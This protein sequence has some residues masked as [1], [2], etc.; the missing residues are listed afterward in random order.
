MW[1]IIDSA[2]LDLLL[3]ERLSSRIDW[4]MLKQFVLLGELTRIVPFLPDIPAKP[5]LRL[6]GLITARLKGS[7]TN[8]PS[9]LHVYLSLSVSDTA[10]EQ[11]TFPVPSSPHF[12]GTPLKPVSVKKHEALLWS[13]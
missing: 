7:K 8:P 10:T 6:L 1:T 13:A 12:I 5:S 2:P 9:S 11:R 3:S 4:D